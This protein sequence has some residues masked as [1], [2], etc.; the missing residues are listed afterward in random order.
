MMKMNNYGVPLKDNLKNK[1]RERSRISNYCFRSILIL[2]K[3]NNRET[4][5]KSYILEEEYSSANKLN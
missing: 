2:N 4:K 5:T 1:E 3:S